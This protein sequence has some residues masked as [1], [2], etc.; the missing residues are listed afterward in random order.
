LTSARYDLIYLDAAIFALKDFILADELFWPIGVS[1]PTGN[2]PF[3]RLTM[4]GLLLARERL[5]ARQLL[6]D[7]EAQFIKL[8]YKMQAIIA[9]WE[10]A[11][12]Y[13]AARAFQMRLNM[14]RDFIE[15]YRKD[16]ESNADRYSY[17]VRLR[18]ILHLLNL[19]V[20]E[21]NSAEMELLA[22]LDKYLRA[23]FIIGDFLWEADISN[24]FSESVYWY[25]YGELP[26]E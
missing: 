4:G 24:G 26:D 10:S 15:E 11:W 16:P 18:V 25:L 7:Q 22:G 17:E 1:P 20:G 8:V 23:V 9:E 2:P 3:P 13:K 12:K 5:N 6:L 19:E 14:W 21:I